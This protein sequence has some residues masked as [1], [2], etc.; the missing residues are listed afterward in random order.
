MSAKST[1]QDKNLKSSKKKLPAKFSVHITLNSTP[2]FDSFDAVP[3][4]YIYL[5]LN[6]LEIIK[7]WR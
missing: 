1:C 2:G 5:D 7:N 4:Y 3:K 6:K